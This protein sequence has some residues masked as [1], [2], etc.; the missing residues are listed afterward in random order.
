MPTPFHPVIVHFPI[1]ISF[2]LPLL[3]MV[4]AYMIKIN[5]MTPR[6]WLIIVG[7]Q[8]FATITGYV[9]LESGETEEDLVEKIVESKYINQHE[10]AAEIFVGAS[11][12]VLVVSVAVFFLKSS[13]QFYVQIG[14]TLLSIV[15]AF[16]G[17]R[18]GK[19]GGELVYVH[20]AASAHLEAPERRIGPEG[21]LPTPG[22]VT[23]ETAPSVD[24]NE[25]LKA[26]DNDYGNVDEESN[27]DDDGSK[28]ED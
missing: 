2:L 4:F 7:L 3:I 19:F 26:D 14:I 16:L 28:Q 23:S 8:M 15:A 11:V 17:Y 5:K 1:V 24:E 22:K 10:N 12:L 21:L 27:T 20:G 13:L 25:S 18:A 6:G 9:A